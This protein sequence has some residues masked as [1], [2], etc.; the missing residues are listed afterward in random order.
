M[1][2]R[3]DSEELVQKVEWALESSF[4]GPAIRAIGEAT[5]T[6]IST[7][8]ILVQFPTSIETVKFVN[9][10]YQEVTRL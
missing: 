6:S 3:N 4:S 5:F 9:T 2:R 1:D 7:E 8:V 10:I